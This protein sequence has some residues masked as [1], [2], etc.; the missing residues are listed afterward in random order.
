MIV[1]QSATASWA[2]GFLSFT[3]TAAT[4]RLV[5]KS[6]LSAF[7]DIRDGQSQRRNRTG[8]FGGLSVAGALSIPS[9][10]PSFVQSVTLGR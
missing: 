8:R 6:C 10:L 3:G 5:P 1:G 4:P 9:G 7:H 2:G